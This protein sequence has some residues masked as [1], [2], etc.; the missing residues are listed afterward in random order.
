MQSAIDAW[1]SAD[2]AEPVAWVQSQ[3]AS[4]DDAGAWIAC[5]GEGG[6]FDALLDSDDDPRAALID[7]VQ[8]AHQEFTAVQIR[9]LA[10]HARHIVELKLEEIE[11]DDEQLAGLLPG[12]A[13][14]SRLRRLTIDGCEYNKALMP[15][16][17][18][19]QL[20]ALRELRI[21]QHWD[22]YKLAGASWL[23]TLERLSQTY[24]SR[25]PS[26]LGPV[27]MPS[28]VELVLD[29]HPE[30]VGETIALITDRTRKPKLARI[31]FDRLPADFVLPTISGL[32]ITRR[33]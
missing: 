31:V 26:W 13:P 17:V 20:P 14:W 32:E 29:V 2:R 25:N 3:I 4:G 8:L 28:L 7:T 16:L 5:S 18:A 33:H 27:E 21:S 11:D 9:R 30:E 6:W 19:T 24:G 10:R 15:G 12:G 1:P 23:R 22:V